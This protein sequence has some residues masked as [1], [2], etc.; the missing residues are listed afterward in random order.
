[1][2]LSSTSSFPS[3]P[4]PPAPCT[5]PVSSLNIHSL[6]TQHPCGPLIDV[7]TQVM[8][9]SLFAFPWASILSALGLSGTTTSRP[10]HQHRF[11][12][13]SFFID[14]TDFLYKISVKWCW[15]TPADFKSKENLWSWLMSLVGMSIQIREIMI[16]ACWNYKDKSTEHFWFLS[17]NYSTASHNNITFSQVMFPEAAKACYNFKMHKERE[18][19]LLHQTLT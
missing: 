7:K 5:P 6:V 19:V 13:Y 1:M 12:T 16:V 3:C 11:S 4:S 18:I 17:L 15:T 9:T 8:I 14:F 2:Q 10:R